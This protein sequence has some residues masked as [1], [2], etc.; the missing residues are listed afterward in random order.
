M[1]VR[2]RI[3]QLGFL[4]GT[5]ALSAA[6]L[7]QFMPVFI[8]GTMMIVLICH[9][10]A[11]WVTAQLFDGRTLTPVVIPLFIMAIG[12]VRVRGLGPEGKAA[13]A[14]SGPICGVL[15]ALGLCIAVL[16]FA[17]PG[18]VVFPLGSLLFELYSATFGSDGRTYRH[19]R[20]QLNAQ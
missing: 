3:V 10:F 12:I 8:V 2:T 5:A 20:R 14:I 1:Q 16:A 4:L 17:T 9:E 6:V 18:L 13:T 19:L 7:L 11:H 15:I